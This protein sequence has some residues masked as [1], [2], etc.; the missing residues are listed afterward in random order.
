MPL[1]DARS[2]FKRFAAEGRCSRPWATTTIQA[3]CAPERELQDAVEK[4]LGR[5]TADS[6]AESLRIASVCLAATVLAAAA[7]IVA[8]GPLQADAAASAAA[9]YKVTRFEE[10][11]ASVIC[12]RGI[13]A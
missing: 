9:D 1:A 3:S 7:G 11:L 10:T 2:S 8:A 12:D 6:G 13:I 5:G 4:V